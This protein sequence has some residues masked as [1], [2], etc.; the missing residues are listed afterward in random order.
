KSTSRVVRTSPRTETAKPP[1]SANRLPKLRNSRAAWARASSGRPS[2]IGQQPF[3]DAGIDLLFGLVRIACAKARALEADRGAH[4]FQCLPGLLFRRA[5]PSLFDVVAP[6]RIHEC[7]LCLPEPSR[8]GRSAL[9]RA[10]REPG[11]E[12]VD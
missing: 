2:V 3:A 6:Q 9:D 1:T 5:P 10:H 12:A 7:I 4:H 11:D 8:D